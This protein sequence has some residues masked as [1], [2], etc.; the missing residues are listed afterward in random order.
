[1]IETVKKAR[2]FSNGELGE[3]EFVPYDPKQG[4]FYT[5]REDG[6]IIYTLTDKGV[7]Q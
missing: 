3:L 7:T 2:R 5:T 4:E 6:V 1:M